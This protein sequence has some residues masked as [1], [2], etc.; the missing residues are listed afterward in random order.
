MP[1]R[2][3]QQC[4]RCVMDTTDPRIEF[5]QQG[6]CNHCRSFEAALKAL[7]VS[8]E[9]KQQ[10]LE[11]LVAEIRQAGRGKP[12]DCV[13]GVSGGMDSTYLAY[14]IKK[15]GLQPIAVHLD[16]GWNT[17]LAESNIRSTLEKLNIKG[18]ILTA[19]W[20]EFKELQLAFLKASVSD[21]EIPTDHAIH[22]VLFQT[23]ERYRL[24]YI[25]LGVNLAT[26]GILPSSWTYGVKD[27][28]YI[29]EVAE[30]YGA[31]PLKTFPHFSFSQLMFY[32]KIR[33]IRVINFLDY[34][35]YNKAEAM[36]TLER[37]LGWRP[38][39]G[40]H[41]ESI[42]TRF[43]QGYILPQKF[44]IDKRK[45]HFST[46]ILSGQMTRE[47]ALQELK[48]PPMDTATLKEDMEYVLQ[49]LGLSE[50]EFQEIMR[51][52]VQTYQN[53]H[54]YKTLANKA[55]ALGLKGLLSRMNLWP[56]V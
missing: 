24:Q 11:R 13:I 25:L 3:Y 31:Q 41:Y 55:E 45:A 38:Y 18:E 5:D 51:Q 46:L 35:P 32:Q 28:T 37:E 12:Y 21:I 8:P 19:D 40:K 44:N 36:Q 9:E 53:F 30:R 42:Y 10:R 4:Q 27:W 34:I 43:V 52:P 14:T 15:L 47:E 49:K 1:E 50:A 33:R 22:A 20:E 7:D 6:I 29:R 16:N 17:E 39:H 56:K 48:K 2:I 54:T 23:A 26:E